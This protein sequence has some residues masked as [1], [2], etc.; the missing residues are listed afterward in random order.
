MGL[1]L[2]RK[3]WKK[4]EKNDMMVVGGWGEADLG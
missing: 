3:N 4:G 2:G 1:G